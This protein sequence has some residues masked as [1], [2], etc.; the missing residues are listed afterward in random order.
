MS[1][2]LLLK[3]DKAAKLAAGL[4]KRSAA[5]E[6]AKQARDHMLYELLELLHR[7]DEQLRQTSRIE[8][9]KAFKAPLP[10]AKDRWMNLLLKRT[11][12]NL[13]A[14]TRSKYAAVLRY[15]RNEKKPE[16]SVRTFVQ[17]N[18]GL[19]GCVA[20]EKKL[21]AK[22]TLP[23]FPD[24]PSSETPGSSDIVLSSSSMSTRPSPQ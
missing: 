11:Y 9:R 2:I 8:A 16:Q 4:E 7:L 5:I 21:R 19:N 20:K 23:F 18:G 22:K 3:I 15:I 24:M 1:N 12:P 13:S 10:F 14:K 17:K 6:S